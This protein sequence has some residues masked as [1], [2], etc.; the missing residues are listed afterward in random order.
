MLLQAKGGLS[1]VTPLLEEGSLRQGIVMKLPSVRD[2]KSFL[3]G[4]LCA[5]VVA[6]VIIQS[7]RAERQRP[8][9]EECSF[10]AFL[11]KKAEI[12]KMRVF[13]REGREYMEVLGF[14]QPGPPYTGPPSYVF[15]RSGT[16][17]A[18]A[19]DTWS[20]DPTDGPVAYKEE[21]QDVAASLAWFGSRGDRIQNSNEPEPPW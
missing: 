5:S 15:D 20:L 14:R 16:L 10:S 6:Y 4:A 9:G 17:V 2:V 11:L 18:W 13:E 8:P 1:Y 21:L 3:V 19:S 7:G 12:Q